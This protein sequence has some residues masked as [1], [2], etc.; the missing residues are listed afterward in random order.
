[1]LTVFVLASGTVLYALCLQGC[2]RPPNHLVMH[3]SFHTRRPT[4]RVQI[5]YDSNKLYLKQ[6]LE[7]D[8]SSALERGTCQKELAKQD[9]ISHTVLVKH[10]LLVWMQL[11]WSSGQSTRMAG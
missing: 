8:Q 2:T 6:V 11:R 3:L 5:F 10:F 1:M 9:L 4:G 7:G